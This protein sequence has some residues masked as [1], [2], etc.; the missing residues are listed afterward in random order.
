MYSNRTGILEI[1]TNVDGVRVNYLRFEQYILIYI[2]QTF[3]IFVQ[4]KQ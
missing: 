3:A 4:L 1:R 2:R